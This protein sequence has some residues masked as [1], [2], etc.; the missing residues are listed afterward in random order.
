MYDIKILHQ[1][2]EEN[3]MFKT[4]IKSAVHCCCYCRL[5]REKL[6]Q[7]VN[8]LFFVTKCF[9]RISI[10]KKMMACKTEANRILSA[11]EQILDLF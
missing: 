9:Q 2:H 8:I 4:A 1:T 3:Y 5:R 7:F 6:S 10:E 11:F